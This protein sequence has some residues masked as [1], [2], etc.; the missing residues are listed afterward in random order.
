MSDTD[1]EQGRDLRRSLS[2]AQNKVEKKT[3]KNAVS[4]CY[5]SLKKLQ[6]IFDQKYLPNSKKKTNS[7]A[8][9]CDLANLQWRSSITTA[10]V[11]IG[12][13]CEKLLSEFESRP[14]VNEFNHATVNEF[15]QNF[16]I[17]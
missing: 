6:N 16:K 12:D 3:M 1:S 15:N 5:E 8:Y 7:V 4:E 11:Q 9:N 10:V 14:T 17:A 13:V 2:T